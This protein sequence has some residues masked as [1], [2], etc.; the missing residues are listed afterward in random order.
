MA[1]SPDVRRYV[2]L[3]LDDRFPQDLVDT[4]LADAAVKFPQWVPN[5][6]DQATVLIEHLAVI[7]SQLIFRLNRLPG[8]VTQV[9]LGLY[10]L[11][12]SMGTAASAD[13][14]FNLADTDGHLI[15]AGTVVGIDKGG[16]EGLAYF[17]TDANLNVA[18]GDATGTIGV[19]ATQ[20]GSVVNGKPAGTV[21]ELV[22]TIA[23]VDSVVLDTDVAGGTDVED[24][25]AYLDR[26]TTRLS[27]LTSTLVRPSQFTADAL[28]NVAVYRA[29]AV[30]DYDPGTGPDPGDNPGHISVAV[31]GVGG[32]VLSGGI[33]AALLADMEAKASG[34]LAI[35]IIDPTVTAVDVT[36][37]VVKKAGYA[38]ADVQ[39]AVT[40][41]LQNYLNP[42]TWGWGD[43]VYHN[44]LIALIDS[45]AS[46]ERVTS[47]T[48]PAADE[49]LGGVANLA[50][51]GAIVVNVT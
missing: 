23:Y 3:S 28:E 1:T 32:A 17:T 11:D 26:G 24:D 14:T 4:A 6:G 30:D 2:D 50:D 18:P 37:T 25:R 16:S 21:I 39:A 40:A 22:D 31:A 42:D 43:T 27:R 33:K 10:N 19:T 34:D 38:D 41:A 47:V 5:E 49:A 35:H 20:V 46:V 36:T 51:A 44:E 45:V 13:V 15:A 12:R 7:V 48:T 8:A 9:L 29:F